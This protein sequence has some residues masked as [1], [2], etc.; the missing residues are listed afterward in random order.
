MTTD[1]D[2]C[3]V[4]VSNI[5]FSTTQEELEALFSGSGKVV[6]CEIVRRP[7]TNESRGFAFVTFEDSES[8]TIAIA[9]Y[10]N[11]KHRGRNLVVRPAEPKVP[12]ED[13]QKQDFET[14][15]RHQ[16]QQFNQSPQVIL[17]VMFVPGYPPPP[18][19]YM[20]I[21]IPGYVHPN[22]KTN[23]QNEPREHSNWKNPSPNCEV[24]RRRT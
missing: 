8:A 2:P 13:R 10:H 6:G 11:Y 9:D 15:H 14:K 19:G 23:R 22:Q 7:G 21:P 17:G 20:F 5:E 24:I 4:Y 3:R 18:P 16:N 12:F 1:F